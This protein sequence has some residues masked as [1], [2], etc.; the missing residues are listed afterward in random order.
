VIPIIYCDNCEEA[1]Q[2]ESHLYPKGILDILNNTQAL[3]SIP[4]HYG[5][6]TDPEAQYPVLESMLRTTDYYKERVKIL[7]IGEQMKITDIYLTRNET[8]EE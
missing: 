6:F 3:T 5:T 1:N 8:R 4:V 2:G 7:K